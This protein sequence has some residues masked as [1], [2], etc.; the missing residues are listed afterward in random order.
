MREKETGNDPETFEFLHAPSTDRRDKIV[1]PDVR[2]SQV[3][4]RSLYLIAVLHIYLLDGVNC[5][6]SKRLADSAPGTPLKELFL[7]FG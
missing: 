4:Q 7:N 1:H 3:A 6:P 5:P 2:K